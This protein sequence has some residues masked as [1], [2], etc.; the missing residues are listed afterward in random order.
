MLC[1]HSLRYS[2]LIATA[3]IAF[4]LWP[5]PT[6]AESDLERHLND[7]YEGKTLILR[8]F[9]SG[10]R[11]TYAPSARAV[12]PSSTDDWTISGIVQ[13]EDLRLSGGHLRIDARRLHMGWLDGRFQE[14]HDHV[15]K[16]AKDE[17]AD[18]TLRLE[19]DLGVE[20][21]DSADKVL[22]QI[23]LT[24]HDRFADL[25][26]DCWKP[27]VLAALNGEGGKEYSKCSFSQD[28]AAIPGVS[29]TTEENAGPEETTASQ[30]HARPL[31]PGNGVGP[32]RLVSHNEPEFSEGARRARYQGTAVLSMVVERN[33][34]APR[35]PNPSTTGDGARPESSG[36][37]IKMAVQS[38]HQRRRTGSRKIAVE[39]DFH[40]Y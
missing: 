14:L 22:S 29:T 8:G 39:V 27:C 37:G 16:P 11:L 26:P 40:L 7:E 34:P 25:V 33:G 15:S 2:T 1:R 36:R 32:P 21:A 31:R 20:T 13:I 28:F 35:H 18:R 23:F 30:P 5:A 6:S 9:Y 12:S 19:V 10:D 4:A 17:K 24:S 3:G 38:R